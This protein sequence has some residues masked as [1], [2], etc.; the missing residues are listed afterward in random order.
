MWSAEQQPP[1][2]AVWRRAP[3]AQDGMTVAQHYR[4]RH[5]DPS[6]IIG[7]ELAKGLLEA[8][9]RREGVADDVLVTVGHDQHRVT[10]A[11]EHGDGRLQGP[12]LYRSTV[13]LAGVEVLLTWRSSYAASETGTRRLKKAAPIDIGSTGRLEDPARHRLREQQPAIRGEGCEAHIKAGL[14]A[15]IGRNDDH[16]GLARRP[17]APDAGR[18]RHRRSAPGRRIGD[19]E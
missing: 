14:G 5:L 11:R 17:R 1:L 19:G 18:P 3:A 9:G 13:E 7:D 10:A 2:V 6:L 12:K 15:I 4:R 16:L 8:G